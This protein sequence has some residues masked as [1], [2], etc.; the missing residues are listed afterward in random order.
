MGL[1]FT[2]LA[3]GS[4][5]NANL[6]QAN[7]FG[8]L[9]DAGLGPRQLNDRLRSAGHSWASVQAMLLTHT[10]SDHWN[11]RTLAWLLRRHIPLYCHLDHHGVLKRYSPAFPEL[12]A[13]GLVRPFT[14][15]EELCLGP[16]LR[17]R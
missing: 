14:A 6:I 13:A 5:G 16:G 17:C 10:H 11:D 1:R 2:N 9:L 4:R 15:G 8:V 7:G 12:Q 3:S